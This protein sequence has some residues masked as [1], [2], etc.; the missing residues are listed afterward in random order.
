MRPQ[1]EAEERVEHHVHLALA[2]Q[3][4]AGRHPWAMPALVRGHGAGTQTMQCNVGGTGHGG[5]GHGARGGGTGRGHGAE[6]WGGGTGQ[7]TGQ[8]HGAWIGFRTWA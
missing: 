3:R 4:H 6:A 1:L 5:T 7:G 8:G 2:A